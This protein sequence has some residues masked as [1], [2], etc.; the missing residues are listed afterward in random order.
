MSVLHITPHWLDQQIQRASYCST[1]SIPG[2][3]FRALMC[4][5]MRVKGYDASGLPQLWEKFQYDEE[6]KLMGSELRALLMLAKRARKT[7]PQL[8]VVSSDRLN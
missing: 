7:R 5:A 4:M 1:A 3:Y 2:D 8:R 6:V